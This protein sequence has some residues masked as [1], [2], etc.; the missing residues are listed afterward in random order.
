MSVTISTEQ[1]T[2]VDL[3]GYDSFS[4]VNDPDNGPGALDKFMASP[5]G[6]A[7]VE[8][9]QSEMAAQAAAQ[10]V[11]DYEA[12]D[13]Q[14]RRALFSEQS[15]QEYGRDADVT[16]QQMLDDHGPAWYEKLGG[17]ISGLFSDAS[18]VA[19]DGV[20]VAVDATVDGVTQNN[21][22]SGQAAD[23][24]SGREQQIDNAV[25]DAVNGGGM[26]M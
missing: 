26:K 16:N 6:E 8:S 7:Q 20:D 9:L 2:F 5:V 15:S 21:G 23:A 3:T 10:G 1:L 17:A 11:D 4:G 13:R 14:I 25:N 19:S 12:S 24:I 22:M 18:D